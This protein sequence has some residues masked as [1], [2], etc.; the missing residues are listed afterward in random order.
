MS[1]ILEGWDAVSLAASCCLFTMDTKVAQCDDSSGKS[2][3][4][5]D[6]GM[7][8]VQAGGDA[9]NAFFCSW[10]KEL[11]FETTGCDFYGSLQKR[12]APL[13]I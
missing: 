10:G 2:F 3:V 12:V 9:N 11:L 8:V 4:T 7:L 5:N 13:S 1:S 6:T